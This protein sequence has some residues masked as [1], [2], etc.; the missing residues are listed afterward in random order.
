MIW[1]NLLVC[2]KNVSMKIEC[3]FRGLFSGCRVQVRKNKS[4]SNNTRLWGVRMKESSPEQE[5]LQK[6]YFNILEISN[7]WKNGSKH[8]NLVQ[9]FK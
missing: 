7:V 1:I 5:D 3:S 2:E 4:E 8:A 6:Q 9:M